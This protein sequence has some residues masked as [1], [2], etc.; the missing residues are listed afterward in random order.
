MHSSKSWDSSRNRFTSVLY[1]NPPQNLFSLFV[2]IIA[3]RIH[4]LFN[5]S[6]LCWSTVW[7]FN[8][9]LRS[10][11][12]FLTLIYC[13][14]LLLII[15][16]YD[17]C[18]SWRLARIIMMMMVIVMMMMVMVFVKFIICGGRARWLFKA[19]IVVLSEHRKKHECRS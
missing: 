7:Y 19:E 16:L 18:L 8:S 6:L 17:S 11:F 13:Y 14:I 12:L 2:I 9:V 15:S 5:N 1:T 10:L 4:Y 3:I